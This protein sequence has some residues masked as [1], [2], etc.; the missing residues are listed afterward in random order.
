M[1]DR[2]GDEFDALIISTAKFGFFIELANLFVEGLVPI[3]TL[4]GDRY[5]YHENGRQIIGERNRRMYSIGD[6]VRVFLDRADS[7]ER[8]LQFGIVDEI[9]NARRKKKNKYRE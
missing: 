3:E 4:P 9:A 5:L 2:I 1:Q 8:K 7:V 6:K